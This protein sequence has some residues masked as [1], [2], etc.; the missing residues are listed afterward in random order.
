MILLQ[1]LSMFYR[2]VH[3]QG[4]IFNIQRYCLHDGEGIRTVVFFKGCPL[5]CP[6]C[7]NPE[8]QS[9]RIEEAKILSRCI[10]CSVCANDEEECPS[11]AITSFG[12]FMTVNE[13]I[14]EILKDSVF[15]HTSGGGVTLSGGEVLT[16]APFALEL[17]KKLKKLGIHTAIET[18]GQG[19]TEML[20]EL[21]EYLDVILYDLKI[22][23]KEKAKLL[24]GAD[25]SLIK[26]NIKMLAPLNITVIPRI[27]LIPGYTMDSDN[28]NE[29]VMF[30]KDLGIKE[31]HLLPFHQYGGN[32]YTFL[33]KTYML[34]NLQPPSE[35][36]VLHLKNQM[37]QLGFNVLIGGL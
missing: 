36:T 15:Y 10:H 2:M 33:I 18:C 20:K 1:E 24:L 29:I 34:E 7:S 13:V 32:K 17:L 30:V 31:I 14:K 28:L 21:A 22:M 26:N 16:Q 23:E 35:E 5:H 3:M 8:S 9:F 11:G 6:W 19:N 37:E 12:K 4:L 25:M 27:P